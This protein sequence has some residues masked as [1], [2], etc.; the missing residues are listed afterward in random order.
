MPTTPHPPPILAVI[1]GASHFPDHPALP[2]SRS[3]LMSAADVEEYI[4]SE[5]RGLALSR[6]NVLYLFDDSRSGGDQVS[7][8]GKFLSKRSP[9]IA[10][11]GGPEDLLIYYVGH[12]LFARGDNAYCLAV[13][14]TEGIN[15]GG[16]SIR[17][18]DLAC[19]IK[20]NAQFLRRYVILDCCFSGKA[21]KEFMGGP[22]A[23]ASE[24]LFKEFPAKGTALFCSSSSEEESL[25]PS[26]RS[27]TMFTGALIKALQLGDR[28]LGARFSLD[29]LNGL[30]MGHLKEEY[31][32]DWK[33]PQVLS[34]D[35][36][37]GDIAKIPLF[38]NPAY[39]TEA[40]E[41][42]R[43]RLERERL[44]AERKASKKAE[45]ERKKKEQERVESGRAEAEQAIPLLPAVL[46]TEDFE[47]TSV[48]RN[49]AP[50]PEVAQPSPTVFTRTLGA[51]T[52]SHTSR[53]LRPHA[54]YYAAIFLLLLSGAFGVRTYV[55]RSGTLRVTITPRDASLS[56]ND[57][58]INGPPFLIE[59]PSG[60]YR[61]V[62]S[63]EGYTSRDER[64]QIGAGQTQHMDIELAPVEHTEVHIIS[65]PSDGLLLLDG[66][67]I[68]ADY[69]QAK[70]R[71]HASGITPGRHVIEIRNTPNFQDWRSEFVKNPSADVILEAHRVPT[72]PT[73]DPTPATERRHRVGMLPSKGK[74]PFVSLTQSDIVTAMKA[75][76]PKV[77]AC[78]DQFGVKGT[79]MAWISVASGGTVDSAS[80]TG[81]FAGT[82]AG[83]CVEQAAQLAKFPACW[84]MR[85]PWP[86]TLSPS[87]VAHVSGLKNESQNKN[88]ID[89][90]AE[91]GK[92]VDLNKQ[93]L[94]SYEG[95]D[96]TTARDSLRKAID[97]AE[98]AGLM[99]D[100]MVARTLL[101]LG[102]VYWVGF[103]DKDLATRNF[104]RAKLIRPDI[105][106]TPSLATP[107][108]KSVFDSASPNPF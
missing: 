40:A 98:H 83:S 19:A 35:Q 96:F 50:F 39:Q 29:A 100:K 53:G 62:V 45:A 38:P 91:R 22:L 5:S 52:E 44:E 47:K 68:F 106:L 57:S 30:V 24:Q 84:P 37:E 21:Y 104:T 66:H 87:S 55:T 92:I 69:E 71:F 42:E 31:G 7:A 34:P 79:A 61:I 11:D 89:Q 99:D 77:Q 46:L 13:R 80:V 90:R 97:V 8:I 17:A 65:Q 20:D 54:K 105:E 23:V 107:D 86:F 27:H 9:T 67:P 108:L 51:K 59:K 94:L 60:V 75:A 63:R 102:A 36:L 33:R 6:E 76:Q 28:R 12:G 70:T 32:E 16:T 4:R 49:S 64:V 18:S 101:H 81:N 73:G 15:V 93:A 72:T 95:G 82:P 85:F 1:L 14:S 56:V 58:I 3:F 103:H 48:K 10:K 41:N 88:V 26:G 74:G 78:A 25:A 43:N 2:G